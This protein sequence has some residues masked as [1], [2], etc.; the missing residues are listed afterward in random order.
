MCDA[1][2]VNTAE[3]DCATNNA[4]MWIGGKFDIYKDAFP[5]ATFTIKFGNGIHVFRGTVDFYFSY[6]SLTT[7]L[8]VD[9]GEGTIILYPTGRQLIPLSVP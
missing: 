8:V 1:V 3:F 2:S 7:H 9:A 4:E 5:N 6:T